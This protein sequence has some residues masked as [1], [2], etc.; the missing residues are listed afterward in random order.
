VTVPIRMTS[1]GTEKVMTFSLDYPLGVL[2]TP[3]VAC[4]ASTPGCVV[5]SNAVTPGKLGVTITAAS[6]VA[7]GLREIANITFQTNV[8]FAPPNAALMFSDTP[9]ARIVK[10]PLG[11]T[12]QATYT[13]GFVI[14]IDGVEGD[15]VGRPS[16]DGTVV[17][18]DVTQIRRFV[19]GIDTPDGSV[20]EFQRADVAPIAT[21]G[22]GLLLPG[23]VVQ[24]RRYSA[25]LDLQQ[26][27]AGP[28]GAALPPLGTGTA[29]I[30]EVAEADTQRALGVTTANADP[31]SRVS[32]NVE[33]ASQGDEA[34]LSFTLAYDASRLRNPQVTLASGM[35]DG[36]VLTVNSNDAM[37]GRIGVLI[38]SSEALAVGSATRQLV[39]VTF[40]VA[41]DATGGAARIRLTD[42]VAPRGVSGTMGET[43]DAR[44]TDGA[45]I[46][47]GP[48]SAGVELSGRILTPDGRGLRNAT[49]TILDAYG[50]ART[51]TTS[52]FGYYRFDG[53]TLGET[54]T[55]G[56][57]S[58]SYHFGA[59]TVTVT[60]NLAD[61]D[62]TAVD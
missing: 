35:S 25:R 13:N 51:V 20:N 28:N 6:A 54:Y 50:Y 19:A 16:G 10:D 62:L 22:D 41:P 47:S 58:R 57:A 38:D 46:I 15:V 59:R 48:A 5:T 53:V 37:R 56:V 4:G 1:Q 49:V 60:D 55:I 27:A 24:A 21:W 14:F 36:A 44:Y 3:T 30:D 29:P 33:L 39:T 32:V 2:N 11:D 43:L 9:S 31:G 42:G 52:S 40:D 34:A 45:V 23:D 17:S 8:G 12:L 61:V 7:A 26:A 18:T